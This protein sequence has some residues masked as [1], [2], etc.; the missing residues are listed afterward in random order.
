MIKAAMFQA[1]T[2]LSDLVRKA[3]RGEQIVLT[4]G[5]DRT[6]VAE[7]IATR[8]QGNRTLGLFLVPGFQIPGDFDTM[9][10]EEL[11]LRDGEECGGFCSTL[12]IFCGPP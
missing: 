12:T 7:I 11:A 6:P 3:Q 10:P 8:V 9:A 4:S 1:T 2:N 5:R